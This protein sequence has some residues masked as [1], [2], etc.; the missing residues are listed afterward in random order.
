LTHSKGQFL[1][2]DVMGILSRP[3]AAIQ[4]EESS[5]QSMHREESQVEELKEEKWGKIERGEEEV[6]MESP[7]VVKTKPRQSRICSKMT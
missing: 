2:K 7:E 6:V 1:I 4:S 3:K 5:L